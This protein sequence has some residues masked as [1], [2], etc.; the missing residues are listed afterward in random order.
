[1]VADPK[2][3]LLWA[4]ARLLEHEYERRSEELVPTAAAEAAIR[5]I[6]EYD[7]DSWRTTFPAKYA[8]EFAQAMGVDEERALDWLQRVIERQLL[9]LEPIEIDLTGGESGPQKRQPGTYYGAV[10]VRI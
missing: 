2:A 9:E 7:R 6:V 10:R 3:E 1:M 4:R 8:A 5:K